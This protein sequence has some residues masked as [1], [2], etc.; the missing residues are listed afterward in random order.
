MVSALPFFRCLVLCSATALAGTAFASSVTPS[1]EYTPAEGMKLGT[2]VLSPDGSSLLAFT[3]GYVPCANPM[4]CNFRSTLRLVRVSLADGREN[5]LFDSESAS[6]RPVAFQTSA[7]A[8]SADGRIAYLLGNGSTNET[9]SQWILTTNGRDTS[10]SVLR[11]RGGDVPLGT[12]LKLSSDGRTLVSSGFVSGPS[13]TFAIEISPEDSRLGEPGLGT[14]SPSGKWV[15]HAGGVNSAIHDAESGRLTGTYPTRH[16]HPWGVDQVHFVTDNLLVETLIDGVRIF[17]IEDGRLVPAGE[18]NRRGILLPNENFHAA[19]VDP[20]G[21]TLVFMSSRGRVGVWNLSTNTELVRPTTVETRLEGD[22]EPV[23][24]RV[25]D[26][27]SFVFGTRSS[28]RVFNI[29]P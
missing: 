19:S 28:F 4:A 22:V 18:I 27:N 12:R 6:D 26:E 25:Q 3:S 14:V 11:R 10:E 29:N 5:L 7:S 23:R 15:F 21:Q 2:H 1:F 9:A 16:G 24:L 17:R 8:I 20:K 13:A